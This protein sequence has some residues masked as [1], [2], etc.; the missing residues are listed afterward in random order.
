MF[1]AMRSIYS[2]IK[3][4]YD[5][6]FRWPV[7]L[8][9]LVFS[10]AAALANEH[11]KFHTTFLGNSNEFRLLNIFLFYAASFFIPMTVVVIFAKDRNRYRS[12]IFWATCLFAV[13]VFSFRVYAR[14]HHTFFDALKDNE[15]LLFWTKCINNIVPAFNLIFPV[16]IWWF[17]N[18]RNQQPF[19][20]IRTKGFDPKPYLLILL[21]MAIPVFLAALQPS[22]QKYYPHVT[23]LFR[24]GHISANKP[25]YA[26]IFETCYAVDFFATEVFFRGFMIL[27]FSKFIGRSIILPVAA[28]YVFIHFGKPLGE[29]IS[30]FFGGVVLGIITYE[31][32]SIWGGVIVHV[33]IA[34]MMELFGYLL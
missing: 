20:G 2:Y 34:W 16:F 29:T 33:G 30:A 27:A 14:Y 10:L 8:F 19:Y 6:E 21:I 17:I 31:T 18:D 3:R 23:R 11:L 22:F 26:A 12:L 9:V 25:F 28:F 15:H 13:M 4:Y 1:T 7:F 5:E 32:R 24:L